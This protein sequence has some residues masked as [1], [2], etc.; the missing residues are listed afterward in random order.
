MF[1]RRSIL[2]F[3]PAGATVTLARRPR[4]EETRIF[5]IG[6]QRNGVPVIA[7]QNQAIEDR[8]RPFGVTVQWVEFAYGPPLLEAM[9]VGAVDFG[10]VGDSPPIFAQAARAD[11]AYVAASASGSSGAAI[12]LPPGSTLQA[13]QELKGKRVAF[14]RGTSAH[15]L[16]LAALEKAGLSYHDIQP[17]Y[18]A[19]A[20]AAAAFTRGQIDAWTVW[21]PYYAIAEGQKGVRVLARS[22]DITPQNSFYLANRAVADRDPRVV[23]AVIDALHKT[24]DWANAHRDQVAQILSDGTGV[25]LPAMQRSVARLSFSVGPMTGTLI[26]QQQLIA[27][28]FRALGLIPAPIRIRDA[29]WRAAA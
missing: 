8:L 7:K 28:R 14:A 12:L 25:P 22:S 16:T 1:S 5:R 2:A 9:R 24:A 29:V 10:S 6:Y 13:L 4:A 17:I 21:D 19:P 3:V 18:L 11:L 26:A 27:D 23:E 20:D 15:N